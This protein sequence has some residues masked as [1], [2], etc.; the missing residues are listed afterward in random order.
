[1]PARREPRLI[2]EDAPEMIP[3]RKHLVLLG[4]ECAAALDQ[5]DAGQLVLAGDLL[6]PQV[7]LHG[8]R[9]V[10]PALHGRVVGDDHAG[11]A[12]H[13]ADAG[14]ESRA[15]QIVVVNALRRERRELEKRRP[16]IEQR[17]DPLAGQQLAGLAVLGARGRAAAPPRCARSAARS[18]VTRACIAAR[19]AANSAP[20]TSILEAILAI[21]APSPSRFAAIV[22]RAVEAQN[23]RTVGLSNDFGSDDNGVLKICPALPTASSISASAKSSTP[24]AIRCGASPR[25]GSRRAP[26]R[27]TAATCF[28]ATCGASSASWASWA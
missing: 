9:I 6:R 3:I 27:S 16:G 28:R 24:C 12:R 8:E 4:Q 19:L 1:M 23:C 21:C 5:I 20:R 2:E 11:A 22:I 7:L 15:R 10:G 26:T 14:D 25:S 13:Q 17:I 18:S